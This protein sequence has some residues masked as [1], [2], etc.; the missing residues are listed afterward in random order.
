VVRRGPGRVLRRPGHRG[1]GPAG[2]PQPDLPGPVR[3]HPVQG[4][5]RPAEP[6]PDLRPRTRAA[7]PPR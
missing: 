5:P 6:V 1:R 3:L 2:R 4:P 7:P